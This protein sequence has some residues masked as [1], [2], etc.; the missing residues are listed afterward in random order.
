MID[1]LSSQMEID[2]GLDKFEKLNALKRRTEEHPKIREWIAKR[3][4]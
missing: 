4:K 1:L 2:V 3:P